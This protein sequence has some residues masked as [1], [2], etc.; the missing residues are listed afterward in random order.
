MPICLPCRKCRFDSGW[1]LFSGV[2]ESLELRRAPLAWMPV[3]AG[4][5]DRRFKSGHGDYRWN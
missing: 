5:R 2:W 4:A 3:V 1:V